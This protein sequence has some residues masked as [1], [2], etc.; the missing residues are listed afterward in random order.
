MRQQENVTDFKFSFLN[1]TILSQKY[2]HVSQ[3]S[4]TYLILKILYSYQPA[5]CMI[6][7]PHPFKKIFC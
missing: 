2:I 1:M 4:Y 3:H 6:Q 5:N 7:D